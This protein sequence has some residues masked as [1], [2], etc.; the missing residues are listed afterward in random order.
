MPRPQ[1]RVSQR[2]SAHHRNPRRDS[3][4]LDEAGLVLD[5]LQAVPDDLDQVGKARDGQVGN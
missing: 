5:L 1:R 3:L 2:T 4:A